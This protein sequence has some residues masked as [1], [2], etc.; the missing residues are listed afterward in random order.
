VIPNSWSIDAV[1]SD[2][3]PKESSLDLTV[4][5]RGRSSRR[6]LSGYMRVAIEVTR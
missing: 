6:P 3:I 4:W 5:T 1:S 2:Q